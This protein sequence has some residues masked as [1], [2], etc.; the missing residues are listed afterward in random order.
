GKSST[1]AGPKAEKAATAEPRLIIKRLIF[2]QGRITAKVTPL[3]KD[4]DLKLP[5][6]NMA[7]LGGR[8]GATP[9]ELA[10]EILQRLI[11]A[12]KTEIKKQ[13]IDAELDKLKAE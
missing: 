10:R 7:N 2:E 9:T 3:D 1:R 6:L 11:D 4:Y 5:S 13:G 8:N 12:A